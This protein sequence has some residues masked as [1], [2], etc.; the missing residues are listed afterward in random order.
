MDPTSSAP[1]HQANMNGNGIE[2]VDHVVDHHA[3][4]G[5]DMMEPAPQ[6]VAPPPT[7]YDD[8]FPPLPASA[9]MGAPLSGGKPVSGGGWSRKPVLQP[10]TFTR[11]LNIPRAERRGQANGGGV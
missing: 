11:V 1:E 5:V 10:T 4:D 9:P 6:P 7:T 2:G 8:L 3:G